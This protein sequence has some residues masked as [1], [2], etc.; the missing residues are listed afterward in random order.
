M[1]TFLAT[2]L[3]G[4]WALFVKKFENIVDPRTMPLIFGIIAP[5][6][7]LP[8]L[9]KELFK[10]KFSRKEKREIVFVIISIFLSTVGGFLFYKSVKTI[11][12]ALATPIVSSY[13]I[14]TLIGSFLFLKEKF[15]KHQY[16]SFAAIMVGIFLCTGNFNVF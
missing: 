8:M 7:W 12:V 1:W 9:K 5:F 15:L 11:Y 10:I 6:I 3:W 16:I 2:I 4:I 13:P 14:F